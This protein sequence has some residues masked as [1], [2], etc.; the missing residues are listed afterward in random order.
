M[1]QDETNLS[2]EIYN[3][4]KSLVFPGF[5][6]EA[7]VLLIKYKLHNIIDKEIKISYS[8]WKGSLKRAII[9]TFETQLNGLLVGESFGLKDADD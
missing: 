3:I 5:I 4:Q 8:K 6:R 7:R 9:N 1:D 2:K